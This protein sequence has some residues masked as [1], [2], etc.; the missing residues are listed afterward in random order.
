MLEKN[1]LDTSIMKLADNQFLYK[2]D[3]SLMWLFNTETGEYWNLNEQSYFALSLFNGKRTIDEIGQL[4]VERYLKSG[5]SKEVL[6]EDFKSL[7]E[8]LITVKV[9]TLKDE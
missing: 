3:D 8:H 7:I 2:L 5:V 6:M 4:Y 1:D 9:I